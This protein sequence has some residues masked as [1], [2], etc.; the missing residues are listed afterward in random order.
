MKTEFARYRRND[1]RLRELADHIEQCPHERRID[2]ARR[3]GVETS[4]LL[5]GHVTDP[6]T[7]LVG[8][9]L[10]S[11]VCGTD[12]CH[13]AGCIAGHACSLWPPKRP[14]TYVSDHAAYVLGMDHDIA[15]HLFVPD[16]LYEWM[17]LEHVTPAAAATACRLFAVGVAPAKVWSMIYPSG[18]DFHEPVT[19]HRCLL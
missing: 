12:G 19:R 17:D 7:R 15:W 4:S 2:T 1:R 14:D 5:M 16:D 18:A 6:D 11:W 3:M 13:T 9:T 10:R 8:F